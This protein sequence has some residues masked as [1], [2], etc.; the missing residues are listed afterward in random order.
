M[1]IITLMGGPSPE[2]EISIKSGEAVSSALK[3]LGHDVLNEDFSDKTY[4]RIVKDK[5]DLVF[6]IMH[7]SPGEDGTVQGMLDILGV[8]YTGSGVLASSLAMNKAALK[9]FLA[10]SDINMPAWFMI[11]GK[12]SIDLTLNRLSA[13]GMDFPI[14]VKPSSCGSTIGLSIVKRESE[15]EK[16]IKEAR[17]FDKQVMVEDFIAGREITVSI[18]GNENPIVLPSQEIVAE[19]GF[20]DYD[21]KYTPGKSHHVFPPGV[22]P[23]SVF[24]AEEMAERAYLESGCRGFARADFII[25]DDGLPFF[26]ELNTLPGMTEVSLVPDA[27]REYGWSFEDLIKY[28]V[29]CAME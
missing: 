6:L 20:Y 8:R 28:I 9:R 22:D 2:R 19:G 7:G 16:A 15:L 4:M 27:A 5:P 17:K 10:G 1:R 14:V 25:D 23:S 18:V 24:K 3:K 13:E 29:E 26:L 12:S 21:A 11:P